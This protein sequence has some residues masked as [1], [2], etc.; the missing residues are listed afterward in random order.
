MTQAAPAAPAASRHT[1]LL[2]G[3][4]SL[5]NAMVW[6]S[7]VP[8]TALL[9]AAFDPYVLATARYL[10]ALPFLWLL[11][12]W[13]GENPF[14]AGAPAWR[15][16]A[17]GSGM[18]AFSILYTVGIGLSNP[19]TASVILT[20]GP[21]VASIMTR[22]LL[23]TPFDRALLVALPLT[24]TGAIVVVLGTPGRSADGMGFRGGELL[25]VLA[26]TCWH[27]YTIKA[28]LW[29]RHLGQIRLSAVTSTA[30]AIWLG[31]LLAGLAAIGAVPSWSWPGLDMILLLVWVSVSGVA[32]AIV[33]WNYSASVLGVPV[34][35]LYLNLQPFF[36]ALTAAAIGVSPTWL[37]ILGGLIVLAGVLYIQL[38]KLR[39]ARR[40]A[41]AADG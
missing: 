22:V 37:Q 29:L 40:A 25:L 6:G 4:G 5:V 18:A 9:L 38:R 34:A 3:G 12:V 20:C 35:A 33:L 10:V 14:V 19:I 27:W 26:Q 11:V 28:Q 39:E 41:G 16:M 23:K 32:F 8:L 30:A 31:V 7:M 1:L 36:A 2:A 15:V 21:I 24:V 17:L 13:R